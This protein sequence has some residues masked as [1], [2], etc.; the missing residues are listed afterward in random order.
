MKKIENFETVLTG[1]WAFVS[2]K[3]VADDACQRITALTSSHLVKIATD[4]SGWNLLYR[5]PDDGRLWELTYPQSELHGGG[6]PQ[7]KCISV[8][9]AKQKYGV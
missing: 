3:M 5:D 7:L 8:S 9:Q 6:P 1:S 2:G 4:V